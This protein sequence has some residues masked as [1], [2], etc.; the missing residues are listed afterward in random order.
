MRWRVLSVVGVSTICLGTVACD[1]RSRPTAVFPVE[2]V[3]EVVRRSPTPEFPDDMGEDVPVSLFYAD[4]VLD[5]DGRVESVGIPANIDARISRAVRT[6]VLTWQF[7]TAGLSYDGRPVRGTASVRFEFEPA[8]RRVTMGYPGGGDERPQASVTRLAFGQLSVTSSI[9]LIDIRD[10]LA[11]RRGHR[12]GALNLPADELEFRIEE[13]VRADVTV[14]LDCSVVD[15]VICDTA[16]ADFVKRG[17]NVVLL[18]H[19]GRPDD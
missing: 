13:E 3:E 2:F 8:T 1:R 14:A 9:M 11:F 18:T 5:I 6:T 19:D 15:Q 16:A 4:L 12:A 10:R 17:R 7:P